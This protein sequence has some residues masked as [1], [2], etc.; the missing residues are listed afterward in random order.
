MPHQLQI[1]S[2]LQKNEFELKLIKS[3]I[4]FPLS[5]IVRQVQDIYVN[6]FSVYIKGDFKS[7][8]R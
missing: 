8:K 3:K 4:K 2:N 5:Q 6:K 1:N 7:V